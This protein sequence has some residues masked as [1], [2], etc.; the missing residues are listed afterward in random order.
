[1]RVGGAQRQKQTLESDDKW[2]Q[3]FVM[4]SLQQFKQYYWMDSTFGWKS[5]AVFW[6]RI[7]EKCGSGADLVNLSPHF[8]FHC[9]ISDQL[10]LFISPSRSLFKW[11]TVPWIEKDATSTSL[12]D[13]ILRRRVLYVEPENGIKK[14]A[15][16]CKWV[17]NKLAHSHTY[18][19]L[20]KLLIESGHLNERYRG[21]S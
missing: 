4:V 15:L 2:R 21:W 14:C 13:R 7:G 9:F 16:L 3:M 10:Q 19:C 18:I 17:L 11:L 1:M 12:P 20:H 8:F 5:S 6:T